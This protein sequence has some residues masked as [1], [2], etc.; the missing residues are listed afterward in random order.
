MFIA[1]F[2]WLIPQG[3]GLENNLRESTIEKLIGENP[4]LQSVQ[5]RLKSAQTLKGKLTSSFLPSLS[6][7]YGRERFTTGP[8][9]RVNQPYGG[10]EAE[11]NL[12]NS[13]KDSL[14]SSL[15]DNQAELAQIESL[16]LRFHLI[17][18]LKKSLSH[19][20]YLSE[21]KTITTKALSLNEM[22]LSR[23]QKRIDAGLS[24][25][26]DLLDF[27]Q[28]KV[29]FTQE[30]ATLDYEIGVTQRLINTLLGFD[31]LQELKIDYT[32]A[33][34]DHSEESKINLKGSSL[35]LKKA[36]LQL[37]SVNLELTRDSRWW[38]PK[39]DLYAYA[40]RFTQK[41]REYDLS[42]QRNDV[43]FGFRFSFPVFDGGEGFT[44]ARATKA[45]VEA[46]RNEFRSQDL[47]LQR[48][49]LDALKKLELA[50]ELIHGAEENVKIM[51]EYRQGVL[52]EYSKGIKNSPDV[53]QAS[54]RW[55][56]ANIRNAEVKKNYQ[57]ARVEAEYLAK[58]QAK[59]N[60]ERMLK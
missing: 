51:S 30:L 48:Q 22:N 41:E 25:K 4:E 42:G 8:F 46:K 58:L 59:T 50:H 12:F 37:D 21:V 6:L 38:A 32:N 57:F 7:S 28:Q 43:T 35:I 60:E 55:I 44:G 20:A 19:F 16:L 18:E 33:H 24:T 34:P 15:I 2:L 17:A 10:I 23:A 54:Q 1:F 45:L 36:Q 47:G 31:P 56:E 5:M 9:H 27:K 11:L 13:G 14:E 3:F 39:L 53:L 49:T 40:L 52:N 26:T 29:Q